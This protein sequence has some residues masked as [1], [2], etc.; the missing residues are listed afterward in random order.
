MSASSVAA[1]IGLLLELIEQAA[2]VSSVIRQAQAEGREVTKDEL[3]QIVAEN[4]AARQALVDAINR[5]S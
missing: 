3:A 2:R 4:D 5:A 1:G